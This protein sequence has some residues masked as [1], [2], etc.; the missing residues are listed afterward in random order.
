MKKFLSLILSLVM[1]SSLSISAFAAEPN[2]TGETAATLNQNANEIDTDDVISSATFKLIP[3]SR[4]TFYGVAGSCTLDYL[5]Q[6]YV[7][8]TINVPG[9]VIVSFDGNL[10]FNKL[11]TPFGTF[12]HSI[13]STRTSGTEDVKYGLSKGSWEVEFTGIATDA[14]GNMYAVVDNATLPFTV[15]Q[16]W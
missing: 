1:V 14:E 10:H 8:W 4:K 2:T 12:D 15:T 6:G 3:L 7:T 16:N 13:F 11:R 5:S 9:A